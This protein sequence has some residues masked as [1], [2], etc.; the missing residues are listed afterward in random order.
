M[1]EITIPGRGDYTIEHLLLD[2]NGTIA[3]DGKIIAGVKERVIT[4]ARNVDVI[5]VTADTNKN[6]EGL[7]KGLPV[8]LLTIH[9]TAE[10]EQKRDLVIKTG[11]H[12]TVS[13]GNGRNDVSMLKESAMGICV[14]GGEGASAEAVMA[15]DVVV[16]KI[17]DALDLLLKPHRLKAT[18]RR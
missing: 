1:I 6:A 18:L 3:L 7:I 15:S 14:I 8:N 9:S 10:D 2:L 11:R 12:I 16:S 4:L 17:H 13:I 5:V